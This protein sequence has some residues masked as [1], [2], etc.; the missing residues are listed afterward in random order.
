MQP[1]PRCAPVWPRSSRCAGSRRLTL[2][3][4][5]TWPTPSRPRSGPAVLPL[6]LPRTCLGP[7]SA[8]LLCVVCKR[9]FPALLSHRMISE[10]QLRS[11]HACVGGR[12]AS[13]PGPGQVLEHLTER[14]GRALEWCDRRPWGV[15]TARMSALVLAGGVASN[16][17]L[18]E[19]CAGV[20][21]RARP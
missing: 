4:R 13:L 12:P 21:A 15:P 18:R 9:Q 17:A 5:Q 2:P 16:T 7:A 19:A 10:I 8:P 6:P 1:G 14:L 20:G 3:C 11:T